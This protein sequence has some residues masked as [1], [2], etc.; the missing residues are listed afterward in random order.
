MKLDKNIKAKV[1]LWKLIPFLANKTAHGIYP[2]VYLPEHI[3][4]D[5][6]SNNPNPYNVALLLHE[7]EHVKRQK[8]QGIVIW[9]LKYIFIPKF[10]FEEELKADISKIDFLKSKNLE[11]DVEKRAKQLSGWIYLWPVSYKEAKEKLNKLI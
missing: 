6:K 10:R 7:Q 2:N 9:L 3:F 4:N 11:F 8:E 1:G 5:L